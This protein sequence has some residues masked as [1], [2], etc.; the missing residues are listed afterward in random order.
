MSANPLRPVLGSLGLTQIRH[1][2]AVPRRKAP[3][4]VRRVYRQTEDDFGVLA[5]PVALHAPAP[6]T[7]AAVW[8]LLR[9]T[10][11]VQGRAPRGVKEAVATAVSVANACP[12][13]AT[14]HNH[15]LVTL[16]HTSSPDTASAG[17]LSDLADW[18]QW[19]QVDDRRLPPPFPPDQL[20]EVVGVAVLL[21]YLNRVVNVL[22]RDVPLPP[23]VPEFALAPVLRVLG[24]MMRR[25]S[26]RPHEAGLSLE[27]L[28]PASLP[29]D[30]SWAAQDRVLAEAFGRACSVIDEAGERAVP[31]VVREMVRSQVVN[32]RGGLRGISR[33]WVDDL[34]AGLPAENRAVGRLALLVAFAS[35]QV[36]D[37]VVEGCRRAGLTDR[38]LVELCSWAAMI[39]SRRIG[40]LL[41]GRRV[42]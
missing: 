8:V 27:L 36:D 16:G 41:A 2:S 12:Y 22:L 1:V 40:E 38:D 3:E 25:A 21:H 31:A 37:A 28:P 15:A 20:A 33:R 26:R 6:Q 4:L 13:C 32:W 7:L 5:P 24:W 23:G 34:V 14:I 35:Y 29:E 10:L 18:L 42:D 39:A 9:E 11:I 19:A 17:E 30:L